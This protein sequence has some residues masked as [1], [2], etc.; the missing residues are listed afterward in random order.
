MWVKDYMITSFT[1][2]KKDLTIEQ[3]VELM[4]KNKTNSIVV[5]DDSNHP[6]GTFSSRTLLK[7]VVPA[8][9]QD[10]PIFSNFGAE[11]TFDKYAEKMKDHK[12]ENIMNKDIHILSINDAM[13]EAASY[14]IKSSRRILPVV[15][16]SGN[17]VGVVTRTCIKNA[18]YNALFKD[19]QIDA[20]NGGNHCK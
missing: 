19:N 12:I 15:D 1:T 3:A 18:L 5:V 13:I 9:L 10:D 7:E 16:D 2:A 11:G 17:M 20:K 14:S 6:I 8:Y 4:V